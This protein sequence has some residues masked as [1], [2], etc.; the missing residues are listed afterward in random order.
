MEN[1]KKKKNYYQNSKNKYYK[2]NNRDKTESKK[3]IT[4]ND[5]INVR[6]EIDEVEVKNQSIDNTISNFRIIAVSIIVLAIIFGS[7]LLFHIL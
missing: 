3:K 6:S 7:L 2:K 1:N 5:L 4:Y